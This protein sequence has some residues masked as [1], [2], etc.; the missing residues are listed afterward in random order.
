MLSENLAL[1][2]LSQS[3]MLLFNNSATTQQSIQNMTTKLN[4]PR[5]EVPCI[6][7]L[8]RDESPF[9]SKV[10]LLEGNTLSINELRLLYL[11]R[12]RPTLKEKEVILLG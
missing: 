9:V 10:L 4:M 2:P 11:K 5:E 7:E 1:L 8:D 12:N 6:I 3:S